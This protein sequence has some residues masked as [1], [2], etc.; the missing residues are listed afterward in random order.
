MA[1][2]QLRMILYTCI[3]TNLQELILKGKSLPNLNMA[4]SVSRTRRRG[5]GVKVALSILA[6]Q[7][8]LLFLNAV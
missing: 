3:Y 2:R 4:L 8:L 5:Y 1:P 7:S 6:K